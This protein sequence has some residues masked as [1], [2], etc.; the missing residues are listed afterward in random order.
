M[1]LFSWLVIGHLIGDWILQN[2]WMAKG[3]QQSWINRAGLTHFSI[4]T[5]VVLAAWGVWGWR[6]QSLG[7]LLTIGAGIFTTHWLIDAGRLAERWAHFYRQSN[8]EVVRL[9]VDQTLHLVV[10]AVVTTLS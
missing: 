1:T 7:Q 6:G 4:Y 9:L 10:L 5:M 3:K 8:V 2:D